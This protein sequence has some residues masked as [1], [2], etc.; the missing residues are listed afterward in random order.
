MK[1]QIILLVIIIISTITIG[2]WGCTNRALQEKER[3]IRDKAMYATRMNFTTTERV[4]TGNVS[5]RLHVNR[6]SPYEENYTAIVFV[7]T[8]EEANQIEGHVLVAWPRLEGY[9]G[10]MLIPGTDA[11][12]DR[13]NGLVRFKNPDVDFRDYGLPENEITIIDVVD[14]WEI[15]WEIIRKYDP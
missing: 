8:A 1:K 6:Q 4:N 2:I 15:V 7:H 11:R 5:G 12:I 9:I 3:E 13:F 14:N 10:E